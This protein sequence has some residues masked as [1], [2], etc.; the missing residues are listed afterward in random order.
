[1]APRRGASQTADALGRERR[2]TPAPAR[3]PERRGSVRL[4]GHQPMRG[5]LAAWLMAGVGMLHRPPWA[6]RKGAAW[7]LR[8][9]HR[10]GAA[11]LLLL[12]TPDRW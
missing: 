3:W 5:Q 7:W 8:S 9:R 6:K 10:A 11:E 4:V 2:I 1:M 12:R